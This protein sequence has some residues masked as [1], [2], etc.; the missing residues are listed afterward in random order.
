M[1]YDN[2]DDLIQE[3][4]EPFRKYGFNKINRNIPENPEIKL[5]LDTFDVNKEKHIENKYFLEEFYI[6]KEL[7]EYFESYFTEFK[8]HHTR[9]LPNIRGHSNVFIGDKD[10]SVRVFVTTDNN[11]LI[12]VDDESIDNEELRSHMHKLPE[13]LQFLM[14]PRNKAISLEDR[15]SYVRDWIQKLLEKLNI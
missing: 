6:T 9:C 14:I 15:E 7:F 12:F 8:G 2:I 1:D 5:V 11:E 13:N 10:Y 4:I 3:T